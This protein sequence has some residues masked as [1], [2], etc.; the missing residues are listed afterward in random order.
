MKREILSSESLQSA[1]RTGHYI[2]AVG[3]RGPCTGVWRHDGVLYHEVSSLHAVDAP[4]EVVSIAQ[5]AARRG[6]RYVLV[7]TAI[8]SRAPDCAT[9][10]GHIIAHRDYF[11]FATSLSGYTLLPDGVV[12]CVDPAISPISTWAWLIACRTCQACAI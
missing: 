2:V 10:C 4:S 11:Y 12:W 6:E 8:P 3:G 7:A 1:L 5:D 9:P